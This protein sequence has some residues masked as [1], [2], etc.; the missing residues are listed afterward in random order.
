[1]IAAIDL[2]TRRLFFLRPPSPPLWN[3]LPGDDDEAPKKCP[4][5]VSLAR[6]LV[7]GLVPAADLAAAEDDDRPAVTERRPPSVVVGRTED[8]AEN[9]DD[10]RERTTEVSF[11][12]VAE[13]A[14]YEALGPTTSA[15]ESIA[16]RHSP[17]PVASSPQTLLRA[18]NNSQGRLGRRS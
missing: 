16:R 5:D 7:E 15:G 18:Q 8:A 10:G 1:M 11:C 4:N 14:R 12:L 3:G 13:F 6:D 9:D 17:S 2:A